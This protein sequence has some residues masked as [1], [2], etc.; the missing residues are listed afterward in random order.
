MRREV[1]RKAWAKCWP[2]LAGVIVAAAAVGSGRWLHEWPVH[3]FGVV[4]PGA[5][6]RSGQPG[7]EQWQ[8]LVEHY[9]I[10]AVIDLREDRPQAGRQIEETR[11]CARAGIRYSKVPIGPDRLTEEELDDILKVMTDPNCRPVLVHCEHGGSRTGVVIAAYRMVVQ[12]WHLEAALAD[13]YRYRRPMNPGYTSYLK[14]LA[15]GEGCG[16]VFVCGSHGATGRAIMEAQA[17]G[18]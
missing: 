4:V 5:V 10:R 15:G 7:G 17:N 1:A 8:R 9:G 2:L 14:Q 3:H 16:P 11:F 13:S 6:Y 18:R 12:G